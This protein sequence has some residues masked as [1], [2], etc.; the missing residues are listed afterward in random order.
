MTQSVL[1]K[2]ASKKK[3]LAAP[4][5]SAPP[6]YQMVC[7]PHCHPPQQHYHQFVICPPP[8]QD[9]VPRAVAPPPIVPRPPSQKM[10]VVSNTCYNCGQVHH[11]VR[12]YTT[13]RPNSAP[14]PRS[15]CNQPPR[16]PTKVVATRTGH[17][18]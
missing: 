15:H 1:N 13:P 18:N 2:K 9:I 5:E 8:H 12:D 3:A 10:G 6:K 11:I 4:S 7:A 16:G 14:H 17:V